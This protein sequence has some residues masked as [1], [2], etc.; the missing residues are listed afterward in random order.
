[1]QFSFLLIAP[2]ASLLQIATGL[3]TEPV[4]EITKLPIVPLNETRFWAELQA[5]KAGDVIAKRD[6]CSSAYPYNQGDMDNL[7]SSL[8]NDG[9]TDY[10]PAGSSSGWSLG[11]AVVCT[12]NQYLFDN[13]H[14]THWEMGWGAGYV[15][16]QC[17]PSESSNP[18]CSGGSCTG[19]GDSGLNVIIATHNSASAC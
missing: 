9:Q 3:P 12:Y 11:T 2:L 5:G 7:I 10:L 19:Q 17:C 1:M 16:G 18:E 6:D 14:V 4:Y 8:Q 15:K 13:T